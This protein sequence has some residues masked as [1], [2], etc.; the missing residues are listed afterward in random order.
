MAGENLRKIHPG[1]AIIL[2]A[3]ELVFCVECFLEVI[4]YLFIR[5]AT[6]LRQAVYFLY[7]LS[8]TCWPLLQSC[9]CVERCLAVA[10]PVTF[11][12]YRLRSYRMVCSTVVWLLSLTYSCFIPLLGYEEISDH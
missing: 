4:S 2:F 1:S 6:M 10:Q 12:K 11:L 9:I 3:V 5:K 8:W 7:Y